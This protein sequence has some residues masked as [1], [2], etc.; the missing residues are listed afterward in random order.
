MTGAPVSETDVRRRTGEADGRQGLFE[1]IA[2]ATYDWESWI[3]TGGRLMW[4]NPAV[5]RLTGYSVAECMAMPDYPLPLVDEQ[6]RAR[7][8]EQLRRGAAGSAG[9]DL[10]FRIRHKDGRVLWGAVSWQALR[11]EHGRQLGVRT[12]VRDITERKRVEQA[13]QRACDEAS[14]ADR[15]K[16]MFLAAASHDLR[17]PLQAASLFLA[18][19]RRR[20]EEA[21]LRGLADSVAACL[22]SGNSLLEALLDVS[23]L[24]AGVLEVHARDFALRDVLDRVV[25]TCSP[26]A[27]EA[28]VELR[29]RVGEETVHADPLL[30][31]RVV[32][33]L[34]SNAIRYAPRGRVL[35]C[36]R[37]RA[38]A[39]RVEVR[40]NGIGIAPDQ[41]QRVFEEFYQVDNPERDRTKG[42]GLGLAI[43][44]RIA[45]LMDARLELRSAPG[46]GS[47]FALE[48]AV[49]QGAVPA[50]EAAGG[51]GEAA[52]A[53]RVVGAIDNEPLALAALTAYLESLGCRV[54]GADS[55]E[56]LLARLREV[57]E[58]PELI[59]ADY[60]LRGRS[61]G[62]QAIETLR[63]HFG[64][65]IPG[66]LLT[67]DTE[68]ARLAEAAAS[69]LPTLHK[70]VVA[71]E[72]LEALGACLG[73]RD[74]G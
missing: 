9:N 49:A 45:R 61:T 7:I 24:D 4:V 41:Q 40:D 28:G 17:Q 68:P 32:E 12:S 30:L 36:A 22:D 37:R 16:S 48:L 54:L 60:R 53:G 1:A 59:V 71:E 52:L 5:E 44:A 3:E 58:T 13:L 74:E 73:R 34:V 10:E 25:E 51:A 56:A 2:N 42:L 57:E 8:A 31:E 29:L 14:R 23:R 33:N 55:C 63:A 43:V 20:L 19:L 39:I 46:R 35:V 18:T 27:G 47:L 15:A 62:V 69:G 50:R 26:A 70:P 64:R 66:L 21:H 11:D 38:G 67:G 72:L 65:S 6:D